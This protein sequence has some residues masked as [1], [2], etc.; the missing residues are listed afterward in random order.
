[1]PSS[2]GQAQ[3]GRSADEQPVGSG[4]EHLGRTC[5]T[6]RLGRADQRAAGADKIVDDHRHLA[7]HVAGEQLAA[8]DAA[9]AE[10]LHIRAADILSGQLLQRLA[11]LL[12]AFGTA[13]VRR[14]SDGIGAPQQR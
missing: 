2:A 12:G 3:F 10:F 8:D 6:A 5:G 11:E 4:R 13:G 9:A 7:V 1:M 14:D